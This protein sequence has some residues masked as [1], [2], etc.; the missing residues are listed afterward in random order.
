MRK[1]QKPRRPTRKTVLFAVW[2]PRNEKQKLEQI[3]E[4][5]GV[6][7]SKLARHALGLLFDAHS[8][9]QLALG[10]PESARPE[11]HFGMQDASL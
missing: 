1:K 9:G 11:S 6:D 2:L 7:Q 10:F 4:K 3:S 8:R 5:T